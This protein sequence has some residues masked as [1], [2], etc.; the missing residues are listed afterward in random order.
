MGPLVLTASS[1]ARASFW[2]RPRYDSEL[3]PRTSQVG[4]DLRAVRTADM[5][6]SEKS[7]YVRT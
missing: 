5:A 2:P 4:T 7:P 3:D 1:F 6:L